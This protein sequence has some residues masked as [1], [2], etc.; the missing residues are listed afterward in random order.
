MSSVPSLSTEMQTLAAFFGSGRYADMAA[1]ARALLAR[2]PDE[3]GLWK[4]LAVAEQL[5]GHNPEVPTREAMRR[6]PRDADLPSNLGAWL[7]G[8]GRWPEAVAAYEQALRLQPGLA[9][10]HNNLGN[11]HL[12]TGQ[13]VAALAAFDAALR[14][15]PGFKLAV[16]NRARALLAL[17]HWREAVSALQ[18]LPAEPAV[19]ALRATAQRAAGQ[20]PQTIETL[21][22]LL[23]LQPGRTTETFEL[24]QCLTELGDANGATQVLRGLLQAYPGHAA[25]ACN[26]AVLAPAE[27][28]GVIGRA[29]AAGQPDE[30]AVTLWSQLGAARLSEGRVTEAMAAYQTASALAPADAEVARQLAYA[31]WRAGDLDAAQA[32]YRTAIALAPQRLAIQSD[33]LLLRT[34]QQTQAEEAAA[35]R[36]EAVALGV[37]I[38]A[39]AVPLVPVRPRGDAPVRLRL[40]L[41]SADLRSH[42]VGRLMQG[43]LPALAERF[44]VVVYASQG[45]D[46]TVSEALRRVAPRWQAVQHLS[47]DALARQIHADGIEVLIELNGHSAGQRLGVLA[48]RP[49][50]L[51][52]SWLGYLGTSGLAAVDGVIGDAAVF[53]PEAEAGFI[54]PLLRLPN[55]FVCW[56][57]P[58]EAPDVTDLPALRPG[59]MGVTFG[60]F[61]QLSKLGP[62][63]LARWARLLDAVPGSRLLVKSDGLRDT[64]ERE[65]FAQ[66]C[67]AA[68][69]SAERLLLEGPSGLGDYLGA[70][71][72][73]DIALDPTP[74]GAGMTALDGLWM[75]VPLLTLPGPAPISRQGLSF[76]RSLGLSAWAATDEADWLRRGAAFAADLDG[77]QQLRATLRA[78]LAASPLCDLPRWAQD[79]E[80]VVRARWAQH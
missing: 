23:N 20:L 16:L 65:R 77:L 56:R 67:L 69:L 8:Q 54:E 34:Y 79:F 53:P 80:A 24:A 9:S 4:A 37:R 25:A 14:A 2:W 59:A 57:P 29:L 36:D 21:R 63:T 3:G 60:A 19:L 39:G 68:G 15:Q 7:A 46:D 44:E 49:A 26:L 52:L 75:G 13:P 18:A 71:G 76:L 31:S 27:A 33:L 22:A 78:R 28:E 51:C 11:A 6:L 41:L 17:E 61:H 43:L 48:R 5:L 10:A 12:A 1:H 70:F 64:G 47:D 62:A 40:G 73:V 72:R 50:P 66:R 35:L 30:M 42:P 55:S 32:H 45:R 38:A 58:Q 74:R